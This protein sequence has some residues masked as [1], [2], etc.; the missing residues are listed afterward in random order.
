MTFRTLFESEGTEEREKKRIVCQHKLK[1]KKREKFF[2]NS[3]ELL[4]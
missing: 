2:D 1:G 3:R 4:V